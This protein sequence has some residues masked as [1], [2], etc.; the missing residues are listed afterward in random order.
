MFYF[1]KKHILQNDCFKVQLYFSHGNV[2]NANT[3]QEQLKTLQNL[4]AM[5]ENFE[6]FCS[7]NEI[8]TGDLNLFSSKKLEYKVG[9]LYLK[10]QSVSHKIKILE[11][12][13]L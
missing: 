12:F 7:N 5:L 6:S 2:Y 13:D 11:T 4:S 9:D 10:K 3:K 8:I 1:Y